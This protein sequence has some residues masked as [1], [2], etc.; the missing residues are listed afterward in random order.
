MRTHFQNRPPSAVHRLKMTKCKKCHTGLPVEARFCHHCGT[1]VIEETFLCPNCG[2]ENGMNALA[3]EGCGASFSLKKEKKDTTKHDI[4]DGSFKE[5]LE[6]EVA[7]RFS[8]AFEKRLKEEHAPS[9]HG[10]Y[11]DRFFKSDFRTSADYRIRQLA[12]YLQGMTGDKKSVEKEKSAILH[13]AFE[14]LT[15]YFIIRF[16]ADL[17][18]AFFPEAILKYQGLDREKIDLGQMIFDY[19]DFENED[20]SVFTNFVTMP[21]KKLKNAADGFLMPK[22]TDT[23]YFICDL[24]ILANCKEGFAMTNEALFWKMPLEKKQRVF[25][26][27][28]KEVKREEDWISIN[29]I[30]FNAGKTLNLKLIRLLKRLRVV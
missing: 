8:L 7:D 24:S 14:E 16:C 13:Q 23:L 9:L 22:K 28:L 11:I 12:E 20:E 18:E 19:L 1:P 10:A 5:E 17:N 26:K 3:C 6:Q 25:Y 15:D 4:F 30:F 27:K 2:T 29:G 21:P